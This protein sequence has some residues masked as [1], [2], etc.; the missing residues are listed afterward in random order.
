MRNIS[1]ALIF[2]GLLLGTFALVGLYSVTK[3]DGFLGLDIDVLLID[4]VLGLFMTAF[5]LAMLLCLFAMDRVLARTAEREA[6]AADGNPPQEDIPLCPSCLTPAELNQHFCM[7][8]WTPLTSQA[9]IDPLGQ[10]YAMGD[11]YW[12]LTRGP[13]KPIVMVG[14]VLLVGPVVLALV[15]GS[16]MFVIA[17]F[18]GELNLFAL[19]AVGLWG[20]I[21]GIEMLLVGLVFVAFQLPY[22]LVLIKAIRN[23]NRRVPRELPCVEYDEG[24]KETES[25][26]NDSG[27]LKHPP[28]APTSLRETRGDM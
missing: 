2:I 12:K 21:E 27:D 4:F 26:P 6:A 7:K 16:V 11:M 18:S 17:L 15:V 8:C 10:I 19:G 13:S 22:A 14:L 23:R 1:Q 24:E 20:V 3:L 5:G 25:V 9:E 28:S